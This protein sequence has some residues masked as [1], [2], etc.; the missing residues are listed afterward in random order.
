LRR[1]RQ[2]CAAGALQAAEKLN[3]RGKKCQ[4]TT[5]VVPQIAE[6]KGGLQP[7]RDAFISHEIPSFSAAC[8][9]HASFLQHYRLG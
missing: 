4:G 7:L 6:N 2:D 1:I 5:S 9:A 3:A 8:E